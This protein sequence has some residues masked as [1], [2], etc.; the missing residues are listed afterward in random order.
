MPDLYVVA[1]Y[2]DHGDGES[3]PMLIGWREI[4]TA[5]EVGEAYLKWH[6]ARP[7]TEK[8]RAGYEAYKREVAKFRELGIK[9]EDCPFGICDFVEFEEW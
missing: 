8:E 1:C 6:N 2:E 3:G 5:D 9:K 4:V 7:I